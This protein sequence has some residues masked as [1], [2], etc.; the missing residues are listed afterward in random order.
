MSAPSRRVSGGGGGEEACVL[1]TDVRLDDLDGGVISAVR[2]QP[3]R[4]SRQPPI[5]R[6]ATY[7]RLIPV[8]LTASPVTE[9]LRDTLSLPP[10]G[11]ASPVV[12][13]TSDCARTGT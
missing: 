3:A 11:E 2:E 4:V 5:T 8:T 13:G 1:Q 6:S 10:P 9:R 7:P 12:A